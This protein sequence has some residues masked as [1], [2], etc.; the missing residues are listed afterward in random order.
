MTW[1]IPTNNLIVTLGV[2][3]FEDPISR[4]IVGALQDGDVRIRRMFIEQLRLS[5]PQ[6]PGEKS[7]WTCGTQI[8]MPD[9]RADIVIAWRSLEGLGQLVVI[10][11]KLHAGE[12]ASQ[13]EVYARPES[14]THLQAT[15]GA[16]LA[17]DGVVP[18]D[19]LPTKFAYLTLFD[20]QPTSDHFAPCARRHGELLSWYEHVAAADLP[21]SILASDW[22]ALVGTFESR[23]KDAHKFPFARGMA[24]DEDDP[25]DARY[26]IFHRFTGEVSR[27]ANLQW[28]G[29]Y[30]DS[31]QGRSWY[32]SHFARSGW[33]PGENRLEER[34]DWENRFVPSRDYWVHMQIHWD[35]MNFDATAPSLTLTLNFETLPYLTQAS[36][37][38]IVIDENVAEA[39]RIRRRRFSADPTLRSALGALGWSFSG[40]WVKVASRD[41]EFGADAMWEDVVGVTAAALKEAAA[42]VTEAVQ[43]LGLD[44]R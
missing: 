42:P 34:G 11:H 29:C 28:W 15:A 16:K 17:V 31:P 30:R 2:A 40:H 5:V 21:S 20:D 12:H 3:K 23:S 18:R 6:L 38:R 1:H 22:A 43:R 44:V 37:A 25:L 13:T 41:L 8:T 26:A 33:H 27:T 36:F 9:G 39:Y 24:S 32:G 7:P 4:F 35:E 10:E 19:W 14:Q